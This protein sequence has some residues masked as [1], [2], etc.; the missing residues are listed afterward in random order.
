MFM[1]G[2]LFFRHRP[3]FSRC[4]ECQAGVTGS[5][6]TPLLYGGSDFSRISD[7]EFCV[8]A[9]SGVR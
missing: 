4:N 5:G 9:Q 3:V 2:G 7:S 8:F 1:M 6:V